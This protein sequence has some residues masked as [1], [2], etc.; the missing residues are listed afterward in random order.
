[1]RKWMKRGES[2]GVGAI[3]AVA[4]LVVLGLSGCTTTNSPVLTPVKVVP[5]YVK[6]DFDSSDTPSEVKMI[7]DKNSPIQVITFAKSLSDGGRNK[8]AA[9]I[10]LDAARRFK[11]QS[12]RFEN[13]CR[14]AAVREY[15]MDGDFSSAK[16]LLTQM[17]SE[18]DIY[19]AASEAGSL[20]K[21][22]KLL[23]TVETKALSQR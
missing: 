8:E 16:K 20:R 22:R 18:Q 11:S 4:V 6:V 1:M 3:L 10:Y 5:E 13:D 19:T 23:E 9:E 7:E 12:G 21:L 15:W 2:N 17:E 14:K